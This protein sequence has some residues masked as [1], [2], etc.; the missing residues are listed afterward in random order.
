MEDLLRIIPISFESYGSSPS[1]GSSSHIKKSLF[2][3]MSG[4][5]GGLI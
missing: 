3:K 1:L 2:V 5:A 4:K